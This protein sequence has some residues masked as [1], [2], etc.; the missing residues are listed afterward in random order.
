MDDFGTGYS[1][2]NVLSEMPINILK[3]DMKFM[4]S[5]TAKRDNKRIFS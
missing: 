3:L 1:S 4:Q 5:E 2:P